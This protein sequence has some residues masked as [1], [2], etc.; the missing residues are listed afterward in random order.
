MTYE[1][2]LI[3]A[4]LTSQQQELLISKLVKLM[5]RLSTS[6]LIILSFETNP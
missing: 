4:S 6:V 3:F 1:R 2:C 5:R